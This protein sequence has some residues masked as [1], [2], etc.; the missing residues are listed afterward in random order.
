MV[1]KTPGLQNSKFLLKPEVSKSPCSLSKHGL[2]RLSPR[3]VL[4]GIFADINKSF[5]SEAPEIESS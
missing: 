3:E 5:H 2:K 1:L 4:S